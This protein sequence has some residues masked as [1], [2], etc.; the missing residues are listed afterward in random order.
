MMSYYFQP[1]RGVSIMGL[2]FAILF[3][4]VCVVSQ[5]ELSFTDDE[6]ESR[7]DP[8]SSNT[9]HVINKLSDTK[10]NSK[11]QTS[12]SKSILTE[13]TTQKPMRS[14][15]TNL[16]SPSGSQTVVVLSNGTEVKLKPFITSSHQKIPQRNPLHSPP[17][18]NTA[19]S[20]AIRFLTQPLRHLILRSFEGYRRLLKEAHQIEDYFRQSLGLSK[21]VRFTSLDPLALPDPVVLEHRD[22]GIPIL[23][24]M[25]F[26]LSD[27]AISGLSNFRVEQLE[28]TDLGRNLYFQH[29]IPHMDSVANY[30]IDYYL[31]DAVKVKI[32]RG[33]MTAR[34]PNARI[35][36]TFQVLPDLM[37]AWFRVARVN[38]TTWVEDLDLRFHPSFL[39]SD[40]FN[41][42]RDT[43]DKIHSAF[44]YFLPNVTE[45]L[46]LTYVKAIE[47]KLT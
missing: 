21:R 6:S 43:V 45:L 31:F 36:G 46:K 17:P 5:E 14:V 18:L 42:D 25:V 2:L 1:L 26:T 29:L 16:N 27:I 44:N 15:S 38:L 12:A 10:I 28:A 4:S 7:F 13:Q 24:R 39:I 3:L 23:G 37:T 19:T 22:R 33:H 20:T 40:Q 9:F 8:Q 34:V 47:M 41:I 35:K 32:S 30:S 11:N